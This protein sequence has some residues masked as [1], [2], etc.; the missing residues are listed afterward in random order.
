MV[1][2]TRAASPATG[3]A[4][5]PA[6]LRL[7]RFSHTIFALPFALAGALMA[8]LAFPG[9]SRLF[10][11]LIAMVGARTTAMALNRL[12][13]ARIDALN[14]RTADRELPAGRVTRPQVAL[15][16][17]AGIAALLVAVSQ[18]PEITWYLW[19]IPVALFAIYPYAKRFTWACHL[20]LGITIGLAPVGGWIAVTGSF[21]LGGILLGLGVATWIAGFDVIYAL[22]DVDFDRAHGIHSLPARFGTRLALSAARALHALTIALLLGAGAASG[23][24]GWYTA[25]VLLCGAVL[26]YEHATADPRD[27]RSIQRAFGSA[28]MLIAVVLLVG[29]I[30]AVL[31]A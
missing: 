18:L 26:V 19:P 4:I 31:T 3:L 6:L 9:V 1:T 30:L 12:V 29:V 14:P 2:S 28:N 16:S 5:V 25:G 23:A 27:E 21:G 13:D 20:I 11:I 24:N 10:W 15:L 22:L 8:E 17:I 7:V